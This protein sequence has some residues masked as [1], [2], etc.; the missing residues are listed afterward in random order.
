MVDFPEA[1]LTEQEEIDQ[2][3]QDIENGCCVGEFTETGEVR[4]ERQT[5]FGR[6]ELPCSDIE[7]KLLD[8]LVRDGL[9]TFEEEL[10]PTLNGDRRRIYRVNREERQRGN[11]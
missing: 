5:L 1:D 9:V 4:L 8:G 10:H 7:T 2:V 6:D 11:Q 3:L